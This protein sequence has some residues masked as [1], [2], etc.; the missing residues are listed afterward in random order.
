MRYTP[1]TA[2]LREI[3]QQGDIGEIVSIQHLEPIGFFHFSHSYVRGNWGNSN[4]SSPMLLA[5]CCH[6]IDWL[7]WITGKKC[8]KISS[9]GSLKYF[10]P[11]NKPEGSG[12]RC[13]ECSVEESCPYSSKKIYLDTVKRGY[14]GWPVHIITEDVPTPES[15]EEA[16]RNGPYGRCV[17]DCDNDVLDNQ[18]VNMMLEDNITISFSVVAF[19]EKICQR[20]TRIWGTKGELEGNGNDIITVYDFL[21]LQKTTYNPEEPTLGH[22]MGDY[23]LMGD[24]IEAVSS[25]DTSFLKS[26]PLETLQSHLIVFAAEEARINSTVLD[27]NNW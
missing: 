15:V 6:D 7:L 4:K 10:V 9:F 24:F 22:L 17:Y 27:L 13:L 25:N 26:T 3:I 12:T 5:K 20:Q 2:K 11:K 16:L 1:Y 19:T 8:L 14:T 23:G 21:T 18:V